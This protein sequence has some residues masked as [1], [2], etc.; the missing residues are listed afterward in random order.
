MKRLWLDAHPSER[1]AAVIRLK[2]GTAADCGRRRISRRRMSG[3]T[4]FCWQHQPSAPT[5]SMCRGTHGP[6][7]VHP[8]E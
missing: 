1:C 6:E 4:R 8:C 7:V 5:C 3:D 2:D